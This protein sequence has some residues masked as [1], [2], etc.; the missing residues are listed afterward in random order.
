MCMLLLSPGMVFVGAQGCQSKA[1]RSRQL[2]HRELL[3]HALQ[4]THTVNT[5]LHL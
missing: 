2:L 4:W 5:H 3:R 1:S